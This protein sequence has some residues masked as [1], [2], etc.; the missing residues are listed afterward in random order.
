MPAELHQS[1]T[2][3]KRT[4]LIAF[5]DGSMRWRRAGRRFERDA[6]ATGWFA[7]VIVYTADRIRAEFPEYFAARAELYE[8]PS[9]GFGY[10]AW[11][12]FL[13]LKH[14]ETAPD[15]ISRVFYL[16]V[17]SHFNVTEAAHK[18]FRLYEERADE[19]GSLL[20]TMPHLPEREWTKPA[21]IEHFSLSE[22]QALEG[23]FVGGVVMLPRTD[24]SLELCREWEAATLL[25]GQRLLRDPVTD[26][27]RGP[28]LK[29]HRHDQSVLS[30]LAKSRGIEGIPDETFF[31][32]DWAERGRDYP[33]WTVRNRSGVRFSSNPPWFRS[34]RIAERA[35]LAARTLGATDRT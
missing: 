3:S 14:L 13:L 11:K 9:P 5:A 25:D 23:Q 31:A 27:E 7:D 30:C 19:T 34:K 8:Q 1:R 21:V 35:Y 29:H 33:I 26:D 6:H 22:E 18:R 17:G 32:P 28:Y 16:D 20:M 15:A 2:L 4:L 10:W 24:A 12:A